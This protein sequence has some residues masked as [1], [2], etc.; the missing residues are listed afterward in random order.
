MLVSILDLKSSVYYN[1]M[2]LLSTSSEPIIVDSLVS[3]EYN[4][5]ICSICHNDLEDDIYSI[6]ECNHNFHNVCIIQWFRSGS[7]TCPYCRSDVDDGLCNSHYD[8]KA[9]FRFKRNFSRRTTAPKQLKKSVERLRKYEQKI[10][11]SNKKF[12]QWTKS[13]EGKQ[14]TKLSKIRLKLRGNRWTKY[15][16]LSTLRAIV[17]NYPIVPSVIPVSLSSS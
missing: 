13:D 15:S 8:R 3:N 12:I 10:K 11:E 6:P 7:S 4:N 2:S 1:K 5:E 17:Q 14:W 9:L 16:R